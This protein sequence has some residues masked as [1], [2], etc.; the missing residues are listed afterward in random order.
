M[1]TFVPG[2]GRFSIRCLDPCS[3]G[4]FRTWNPVHAVRQENHGVD[5]RGSTVDQ[6]PDPRLRRRRSAPASSGSWGLDR[7]HVF[8]CRVGQTWCSGSHHSIE[9]TASSRMPQ[10]LSVFVSRR[11]TSRSTTMSSSSR[12]P[13]AVA[14]IRMTFGLVIPSPPVENLAPPH[15][16]ER[17]QAI[18]D[19]EKI[20]AGDPAPTERAIH[21]DTGQAPRRPEL[22]R[23]RR[24]TRNVWSFGGVGLDG[25]LGPFSLPVLAVHF[26]RPS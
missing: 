15:T 25:L 6:A 3:C 8:R 17:H 19:A 14:D 10:I 13:C 1:S 23:V 18:L 9:H 11:D 5:D 24:L 26:T 21:V 7:V 22:K 2:G 20:G 16:F 12:R 4:A